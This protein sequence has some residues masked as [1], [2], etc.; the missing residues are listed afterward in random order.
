MHEDDE[1][2][3]EEA[4]SKS[5]LKR[6]MHTLQ[7]LGERLVALS[8][9]QLANMPIN[10]ERL[11]E[12][13]QLAQR[14]KSHSGRRRQLQY[15]GKLMRSIDPEPLKNAFAEIDGQR[16]EEAARFHQLEAL[17]DALLNDGDSAIGIVAQRYAQVDRGHLRQLLRNHQRE[18]SEQKPLSAARAIFRYLRELDEQSEQSD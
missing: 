16:Q 13:V 8:A 2:F 11:L 18:Q 10:D 7:A 5:E 3:A 9:S 14:I 1:L 15:I 4:P 6:Q 17:R 12:A